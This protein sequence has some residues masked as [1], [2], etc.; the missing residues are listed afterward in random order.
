M[1]SQPVPSLGDMSG[2]QEYAGHSRELARRYAVSEAQFS[3]F[4]GDHFARAFKQ[5]TGITP[6][7]YLVRAQDMLTHTALSPSE[8]AYTVGFSDQSH[9]AHHLRHALGIT[10]GR[11]RWLQN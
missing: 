6:H 3:G 4:S 11:F 1:P 8:V 2:T 7:R 5:S 9:L 10:P